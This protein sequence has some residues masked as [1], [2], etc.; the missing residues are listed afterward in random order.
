MLKSF[1]RKFFV[2]VFLAT[3]LFSPA[4]AAEDY[5]IENQPQVIEKVVKIQQKGILKQKDNG[6]LYE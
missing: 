6:Y 1:I 5:Q 3:S 4:F 2:I